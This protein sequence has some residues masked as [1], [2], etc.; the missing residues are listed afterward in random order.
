MVSVEVNRP[1][2]KKP[3]F[4]TSFKEMDTIG[5]HKA[6]DAIGADK[7]VFPTAVSEVIFGKKVMELTVRG[8]K[9]TIKSS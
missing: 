4:S 9:V 5:M 3:I 7:E 6:C 2:V 8:M 1:G